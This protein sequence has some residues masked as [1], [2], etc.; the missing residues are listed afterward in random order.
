MSDLTNLF[1]NNS[2]WAASMTAQDPDFFHRL[3]AQQ[4][5]E[6]LWIGCSDSR[7]PANE[8]AR[9]Q[10]DDLIGTAMSPMWWATLTSTACR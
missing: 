5:P 4:A 9:Q 8:I 7:V 1:T 10:P 6:Y 3:S 2:R